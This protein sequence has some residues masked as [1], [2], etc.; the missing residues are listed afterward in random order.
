MH[1][2]LS[3]HQKLKAA[4]KENAR[5]DEVRQWLKGNF[6]WDQEFR[7]HY[8]KVFVSNGCESMNSLKLINN[9]QDLLDMGIVAKFHRL[10][11]MNEIQKLKVPFGNGITDEDVITN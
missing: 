3:L 9:E 1:K 5:L 11:L 10:K 8:F 2:T 4:Q 7:E 6:D